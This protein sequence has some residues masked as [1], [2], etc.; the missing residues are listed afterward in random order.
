MLVRELVR[1]LDALLFAIPGE[2]GVLI[3][4]HIMKYRFKQ[5]GANLRL[6]NSVRILGH[7]LINLNDNVFIS[8][9]S[10][11]IALNSNI[12]I[13]SGVHINQNVNISA[14]DG[15]NITIGSNCLIASGVIIRSANHK[16]NRVD[17]PIKLQGHI[18]GD[19]I[20]EEDVWIASN[21]VILPNV[22]VGKG[23]IIA[24]GA[25]VNKNVEPYTIVGGITA[26]LLKKRN[27]E[28]DRR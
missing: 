10:T 13:G 3:R 17:I 11:L 6:D 20:I 8:R 16:T 4:Y 14:S 28:D 2:I 9:N 23:A 27:L 19:I 22:V 1:W 25:V 7:N 24:A 18:S 5:C 26:K 15:G 12:K 21:V